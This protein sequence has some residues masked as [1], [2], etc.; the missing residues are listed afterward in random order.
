MN[1]KSSIWEKKDKRKSTKCSFPKMK[2]IQNLNQMT[3]W[4]KNLRKL[5]SLQDFPTILDPLLE[6]K[7]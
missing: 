7:L 2:N 1:L 6:E 5:V 4:K 3:K